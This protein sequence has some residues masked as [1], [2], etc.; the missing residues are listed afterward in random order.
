M[1]T[2]IHIFKRRNLRF[3]VSQARGV[4]SKAGTR[5]GTL[6]PEHSLHCI[7][8]SLLLSYFRTSYYVSV[9]LS[10]SGW[11]LDT[12]A[13]F[14]SFWITEWLGAQSLSSNDPRFAL[15]LQQWLGCT[16]GILSVNTQCAGFQH[17][18]MHSNCLME[19]LGGQGMQQ[20]LYKC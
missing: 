17:A 13:V 10:H 16:L 4:K 7:V 20:I 18:L 9:P 3:R 19:L 11:I 14:L 1:I 12:W 15:C 2:R 5:A 8:Y 6:A